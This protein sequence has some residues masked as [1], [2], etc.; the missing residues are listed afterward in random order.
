MSALLFLGLFN[1]LAFLPVLLAYVGPPA[2]VIPAHGAAAIR[3]EPSEQQQHRQKSSRRSK[4]AI[5]EED[6]PPRKPLS[7][8][9]EESHSHVS[10]SYGNN[11]A[12][13]G[14]SVD[15]GGGGTSFRVEPEVTLAIPT[16]SLVRFFT[17]TFDTIT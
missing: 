9:A 5:L 10:S 2:E 13:L 6:M 17:N 1:G 15:N 11:N 14:G 12:S 4:R 3:V 8:I 16:S 7:T